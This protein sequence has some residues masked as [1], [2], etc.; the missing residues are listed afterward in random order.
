MSY[1]VITCCGVC[2]YSLGRSNNFTHSTNTQ[3]SVY[4]GPKMAPVIKNVEVETVE[5]RNYAE[6]ERRERVSDR[7]DTS[8]E[9]EEPSCCKVEEEEEE[10]LVV[11]KKQTPVWLTGEE[12]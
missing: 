11:A 1:D 7:T 12:P 9:E 10:E 3:S 4:Q 2:V 5:R 6:A 8:V